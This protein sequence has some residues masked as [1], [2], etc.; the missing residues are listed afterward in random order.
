MRKPLRAEVAPEI[1]LPRGLTASIRA[2]A[3]EF[4]RDRDTISR[5]ITESNVKPAALGERGHPVYRWSDLHAVAF[6][7]EED[8]D[9]L[10]PFRRKA[11]YQCELDKLKLQTERGELIPRI[12]AEQEQARAMKLVAQVFDTLPDVVERDCGASPAVLARLER[13]L[14]NARNE[15]HRML[16]AGEEEDES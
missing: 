14:D 4:N 8:P 7:T 6:G 15:L 2:F 5:R 12:E 9:K 16:V 11:H 13:A 10:D 3:E 1:K